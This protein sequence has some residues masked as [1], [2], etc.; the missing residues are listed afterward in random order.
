[1]HL[2]FYEFELTRNLNSLITLSLIEH[3][4]ITAEYGDVFLL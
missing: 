4:A 3:E 1:M 2:D